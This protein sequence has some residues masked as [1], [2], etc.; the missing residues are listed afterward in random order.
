MLMFSRPSIRLVILLTTALVE[1]TA[2][3]TEE[4]VGSTEMDMLMIRSR[5]VMLLIYG[6][7]KCKCGWV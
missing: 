3:V 2:S 5:V 6:T 7:T 4:V 1:V